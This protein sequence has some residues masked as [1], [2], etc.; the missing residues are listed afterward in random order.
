MGP[1]VL[2]GAALQVSGYSRGDKCTPFCDSEIQ[3]CS[4]QEENVPEKLVGWLEHFVHLMGW[5]VMALGCAGEV[6]S[7]F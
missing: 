5:E 6:Q 7:G 3:Q 4:M 2:G 1:A